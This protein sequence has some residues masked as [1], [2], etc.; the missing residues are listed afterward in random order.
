MVWAWPHTG[1]PVPLGA[2]DVRNELPAID[3]AFGLSGLHHPEW[4]RDP[5]THNRARRYCCP[6]W[7][8][9]TE[10][11]SKQIKS[12]SFVV[13]VVVILTFGVRSRFS[14]T[15]VC[16]SRLA[17]GHQMVCTVL[18]MESL[19]GEKKRRDIGSPKRVQKRKKTLTTCATLCSPQLGY[20]ANQHDMF[21]KGRLPAASQTEAM[22]LVDAFCCW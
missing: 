17:L 4:V 6:R 8:M 11:P 20:M 5:E 12:G 16:T 7:W 3:T 18:A 15:D 10:T 22:D 2:P 21:G 19:S 13:G 9:Q 1:F 14:P